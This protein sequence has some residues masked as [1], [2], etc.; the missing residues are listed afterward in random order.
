ME[1]RKKFFLISAEVETLKKDLEIARKII[2]IANV[3]FQQEVNKVM[4]YQPSSNLQKPEKTPKKEEVIQDEG[5]HRNNSPSDEDFSVSSKK[6]TEEKIIF[7]KIASK[8][9]P[10]KVQ[11]MK[12]FEKEYKTEL[13]DRARQAA[14]D[15]DYHEV[16]K[17]AEELGIDMPPPTVETLKSLIRTRDKVSTELNSLKQ[18]ACFLW[19]LEDEE[20]QRK[21]YINK[22]IEQNFT[23]KA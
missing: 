13:F 14:A 8:I 1:L 10:D 23:K 11:N 18:S 21:I 16:Y 9:H 5:T 17:I 3:D 19:Y 2:K 20:A 7:K 12:G 22:Y 6:K 4:G 15:E